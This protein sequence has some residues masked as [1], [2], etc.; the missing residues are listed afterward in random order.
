MSN[1][2]GNR[3]ELIE[4]RIDKAATSALAIDRH[5]QITFGNA[6]EIMEFAKMMALGKQALP[7]HLRESPGACLAIC[8]QACAWQMS[9]FA[10]AGKSYVVN[11]RMGYEAQLV[12][13]VIQKLAPI[14]GRIK[15]KFRGEG[16]TRV[17]IVSCQP[18]DDPDLIEH[19]SPEIGKIK[20]KNSPLW[21]ADPDQQL[22]Y[23]TVRAMARRHFPDV[24]LGVYTPDELAEETLRDVTPPAP[25]VAIPDQ[26]P[27]AQNLGAAQSRSWSG[28][29]GPPAPPDPTPE[30]QTKPAAEPGPTNPVV[31]P[32]PVDPTDEEAARLEAVSRINRLMGEAGMSMGHFK[33]RCVE[34]GITEAS[35]ML[36]KMTLEQLQKVTSDWAGFVGESAKSEESA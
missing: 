18:T 2:P 16:H 17:C 20:T 25:T 7:G 33:A 36:S 4:S 19:E 30:P 21:T 27:T 24:L 14:K 1:I 9:P 32:T 26:A 23:Y 10:V 34:L 13:A 12:A 5:G 6:N 3:S 15:Y 28:D 35:T 11:D 29:P 22:G 31:P 8:I